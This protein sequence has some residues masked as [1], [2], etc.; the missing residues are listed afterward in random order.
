M[1]KRRFTLLTHVELDINPDQ[2]NAWQ[3]FKSFLEELRDITNLRSLKLAQYDAAWVD[4]LLEEYRSLLD[5]LIST[6]S[7]MTATTTP[8]LRSCTSPLNISTVV[9]RLTGSGAMSTSVLG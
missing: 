3:M 4:K 6:E 7:H 8:A 1:G 9:F 5:F 2:P